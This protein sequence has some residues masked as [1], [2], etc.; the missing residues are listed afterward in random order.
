MVL[1]EFN[2]IL[3]IK[4]AIIVNRIISCST[5]A[6][7]DLSAVTPYAIVENGTINSNSSLPINQTLTSLVNSIRTSMYIDEKT[8]P[9][10]DNVFTV[11]IKV[12]EEIGDAKTTRKQA[13]QVMVLSTRSRPSMKNQTLPTLPAI[14]REM[15][16]STVMNVLDLV[17]MYKDSQFTRGSQ[18]FS[19]APSRCICVFSIRVEQ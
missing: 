7:L 18:S 1:N 17:S 15:S 2:C 14:P 9:T 8:D 12:T 19:L 16:V 10:K 3:A 5:I 4:F 13:D 6:E 11:K